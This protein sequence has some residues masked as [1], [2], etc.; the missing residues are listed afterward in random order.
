MPR[1]FFTTSSERLVVGD[2]EGI[3]LPHDT[4]L[5][6]MVCGALANL[7]AAEVDNS[8][9]QTFSIC[10]SNARGEDVLTATLQFTIRGDGV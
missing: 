7:F 2:D 10:A 9:S 5:H 1:Y 4:A 8:P 6:K 3:E